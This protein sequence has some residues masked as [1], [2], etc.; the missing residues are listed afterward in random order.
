MRHKK[1]IHLIQLLW[2]NLWKVTI[3]MLGIHQIFLPTTD[4]PRPRIHLFKE[5]QLIV[6]Y[7]NGTIW[8]FHSQKISIPF[9][10]PKNGNLKR[11]RRDWFCKTSII[12]IIGREWFIF[13]AGKAAFS[14][15]VFSSLFNSCT[16][17]RGPISQCRAC[18]ETARYL[19]NWRSGGEEHLEICDRKA[20]F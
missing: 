8:T 17:L 19:K 4:R 11:M 13:L 15:S 20:L 1:T 5:A 16:L 14:N 6:N 7:R 12:R 18:L 9:H 10:K 2:T 3:Q